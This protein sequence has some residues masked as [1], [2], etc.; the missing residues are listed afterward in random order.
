MT[1]A[2]YRELLAT[3][4]GEQKIFE[5]GMLPGLPAAGPRP[6]E[7][8]LQSRWF[9]GEFGHQFLTTSGQQVEIV[10]FGIW[11]HAAGPDFSEVAVRVGGRLLT[12]HLELDWDARDWER[13][14]HAENPAYEKVVLHVFFDQPQGSS[15]FTRTAS[16]REVPQV[17]IDL[18]VFPQVGPPPPPAEAR[19][20]RCSFPLHELAEGALESLFE[21][22]ARQ[23][24]ERK[25]RRL[26]R[27]AAL[28]GW[29]QALFQELAAALGY[30]RNQWA[31]TMLAQRL[32]L[33]LLGAH[34]A[35]PEALLFGAA[36]F[37]EARIYELAP[38][39]SRDYLRTL[40]QAW[41]KY[42]SDFCAV[43]PPSWS[44]AGTR[45]QNHPH[46]RLGALAQIV[47]QWKKVRAAFEPSVRSGQPPGRALTDVLAAMHHPFW[48][49]HF[50]LTSAPSAES[51]ALVGTSRIH[52]ILANLAF[53]RL[54]LRP[55]SAAALWSAYAAVP[56]A[57]DNEKSRRAALRLLGRRPDVARW[58]KKLLYQQ[59]LLQIYED[60]CLQDSSDC[61]Q[62]LFPEQLAR[63][64]GRPEWQGGEAD[65][66][67]RG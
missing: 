51:L 15:F 48:D 27:L 36:G 42:R 25:A 33:S 57:L 30:R 49:R 21:A 14:G 1:L 5:D 64:T 54:S 45:P 11:N 35:G 17:R 47:R 24:L 4:A 7:S 13:H 65:G 58:Q 52:D 3:V 29:D 59:A 63:W 53:P 2:A 32:P 6:P 31:M 38:P 46:R 67:K 55:E 34:P 41:W 18:A 20:G 44:L 62:C 28:H 61:A 56:A 40:W 26:D 50:T 16:H 66:Q 22:A 19:C 23:R 12:G 10:Q 37:L 43:S 60:F 8:E 39:D 9:A